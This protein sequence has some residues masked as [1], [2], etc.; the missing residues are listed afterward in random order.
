[1]DTLKIKKLQNHIYVLHVGCD[2]GYLG[3]IPN[4]SVHGARRNICCMVLA[5]YNTL[6]M[7]A[8][9]L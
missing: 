4:H 6:W 8:P 1:M 7:V 5:F 9:A 2:C 3:N